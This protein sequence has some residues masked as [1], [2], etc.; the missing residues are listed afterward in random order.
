[1]N[2][3]TR[4]MCGGWG[5]AEGRELNS[6]QG[7][8]AVVERL[9]A[10][11]ETGLEPEEITP[12]IGHWEMLSYDEAVCSCCGYDRNTPFDS[13]REAKEKWS[14]LPPYCEMCGAKLNERAAE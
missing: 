7:K 9:A 13:T 12:K 6:I 5:L 4:R 3:L 1:M 14:E 8:R 10:Y 2:R 11:E